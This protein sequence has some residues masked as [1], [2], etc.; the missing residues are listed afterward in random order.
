[1]TCTE[2]AP[3]P[4]TQHM[5][6][7]TEAHARVSRRARSR[8]C[9]RQLSHCSL[10]SRLLRHPAHQS[11]AEE[12]PTVL[13]V[14]TYLVVRGTGG[15]RGAPLK[16][17]RR[18]R[19]C[20]RRGTPRNL[21]AQLR[22]GAPRHTHRANSLQLRS[23]FP[24]RSLALVLSHSRVLSGRM[25]VIGAMIP[26]TV[27]CWVRRAPSVPARAQTRPAARRTNKN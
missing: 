8:R 6:E 12:R 23:S 20:G 1:M 19:L 21:W 9:R 13:A 16:G 7:Y 24:G 18:R 26:A 22:H 11:S 10:L 5:Y 4:V 2:A 17:V 25:C 3:S 15:R 14:R 27:H